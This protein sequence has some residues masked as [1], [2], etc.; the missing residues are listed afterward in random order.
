MDKKLN[1]SVKMPRSIN[2]IN[3][4]LVSSILSSMSFFQKMIFRLRGT[5]FIGEAKLEGWK[6]RIP[7]Y[8]FK[9]EKHGYQ[10]GYPSGYG[11][12]LICIDCLRERIGQLPAQSQEILKRVMSD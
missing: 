11:M 9:C 10:I 5:V 3:R 7:F 4:E 8:L 6:D 1:S 2:E 12:T